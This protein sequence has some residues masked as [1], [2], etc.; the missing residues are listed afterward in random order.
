MVPSQSVS[1]KHGYWEKKRQQHLGGIN[2]LSVRQAADLQNIRDPKPCERPHPKVD[3]HQVPIPTANSLKGGAC[4]APSENMGEAK[5]RPTR[6]AVARKPSWVFEIPNSPCIP[7]PI[8]ASSV[9]RE[10]LTPLQEMTPATS[11]GGKRSSG[12]TKIDSQLAVYKHK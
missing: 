7:E 12:P 9:R 6:N 3:R 8:G 5:S 1:G 2:D 4:L 10:P 11:T